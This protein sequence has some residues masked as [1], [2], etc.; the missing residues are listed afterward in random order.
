MNIEY[1]PDHATVTLVSEITDET[2]IDLT[3]AMRHLRR[4]CFYDWAHL[5]IA[6]PGGTETA[7][8]HWLAVADD[9]RDIGLRLV[10][11]GLACVGSAAAV[12][13]SLGDRREAKRDTRLHYHGVRIA[14]DGTLTAQQAAHQ[15]E[16]MDRIDRDVR[17]HL[18]D[19]ALQATTGHLPMRELTV[20]D[21]LVAEN[22]V[23]HVDWPRRDESA[24][25]GGKAGDATLSRLRRL[26]AWCAE[27]PRARF[28]ALYGRLLRL[29]QTISATLALE[30]ALI[31]RIVNGRDDGR[32]ERPK[33][34]FRIPHWSALFPAGEVARDALC[35]HVLVLGE[36]G[37][38]KTA[39]AILPAVAAACDPANR[40]GCALVIDPKREIKEVASE[41]AGTDLRVF[42][43]GERGGVRQVVNVMASPEWSVEA[44]LAA[45]RVRTAARKI[46]LRSASLVPGSPAATLNGAPAKAPDGYWEMEGAKFALTVVATTLALFRS[47]AWRSPRNPDAPREQPNVL[48]L[49][50]HVLARFFGQKDCGQLAMKLA[51]RFNKAS[52]ETRGLAD[53]IRQWAALAD[54]RGQYAASTRWLGRRSETS[55]TGWRPERSTSAPSPRSRR[56]S[57]TATWPPWSSAR[58]WT[59]QR[60]APCISTSR[61]WPDRTTC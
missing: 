60:A 17:A 42:E 59:R 35:R 15:A 32:R 21:R 16:I 50:N 10:T 43:P 18:A 46:L 19:R 13:L 45:G 6:S 24:A 52:G 39:S 8:N 2:V 44:D 4:D 29:D 54:T 56:A 11:R 55:A 48:A 47:V 22:L 53:D 38:G 31:D 12:M 41:L 1:G 9:L 7:L 37:S 27:G 33:S 3:A 49:A 14:G 23:R 51:D 5:E 61:V 20:E 40:V 28:A 26:V 36:P 58:A 57:P 34:V 30:L 25:N